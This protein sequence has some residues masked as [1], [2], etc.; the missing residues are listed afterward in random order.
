MC[1]CLNT[2]ELCHPGCRCGQGECPCVDDF[3]PLALAARLL[4][5]TSLENTGL[6]L[7]VFR[8]GPYSYKRAGPEYFASREQAV[9]V[10]RRRLQ[11]IAEV[12]TYNERL[13]QAMRYCP[14]PRNR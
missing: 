14:W 9:W 6:E 4:N 7:Y 13:D 3:P 12:A 2:I 5:T 11:K 10:K 1:C 8:R